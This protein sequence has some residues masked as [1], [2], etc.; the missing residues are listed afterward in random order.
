MNISLFEKVKLQKELIDW[1]YNMQNYYIIQYDSNDKP[2]RK[3]AEQTI[4]ENIPELLL[5][6]YDDM[7]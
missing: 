3:R 5:F 1:H 6:S 2:D 4:R 7:H